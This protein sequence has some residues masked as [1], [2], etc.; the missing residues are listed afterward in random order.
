MCRPI[1]CGEPPMLPSSAVALINGSSQWK[2]V[3]VYSCL[4]GYTMENLPVTVKQSVCQVLSIF[5]DLE[6]KI[7]L[8]FYLSSYLLEYTMENL[9]VTVKQSVCQLSIYLFVYLSIYLFVY[10]SIY[11]FIYFFIYL[12][13]TV[14]HSICQ[15]SIYLFVYLSIFLDLEWKTIYL[16]VCLEL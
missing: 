13:V 11:L 12:S 4:P 1:S 6:R 10:L 2:S 3:A 14:K 8:S 9:P 15:V 16:S 7:N 5:L